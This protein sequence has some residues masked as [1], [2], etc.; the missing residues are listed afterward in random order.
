MEKSFAYLSIENQM[1]TISKFS[2][3][4]MI[5]TDITMLCRIDKDIV[6]L[7]SFLLVAKRKE[8]EAVNSSCSGFE[9]GR[10]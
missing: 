5:E 10:D 1:L 6:S 3:K 7:C 8:N 4:S 9:W 2:T